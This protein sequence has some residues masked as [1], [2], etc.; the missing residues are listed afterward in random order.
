MLFFLQ[1]STSATLPSHPLTVTVTAIS[2][3][4]RSSMPPSSIAYL[5]LHRQRRLH[6]YD[7]ILQHSLISKD[8]KTIEGRLVKRNIG[9][10]PIELN[11]EIATTIVVFAEPADSQVFGVHALEGLGLEID[12]ITEKVKKAEALLAV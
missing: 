9:E 2:D 5:L 3:L 10:A 1:N 11:S 4:F 7:K 12:P 6:F 8:F